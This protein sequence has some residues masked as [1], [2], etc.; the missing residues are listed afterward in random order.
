MKKAI[1]LYNEKE[2]FTKILNNDEILIQKI[3]NYD[4]FYNLKI[5]IEECKQGG[6]VIVIYNNSVK[7]NKSDLPNNIKSIINSCFNNFVIDSKIP[8][9]V[10]KQECA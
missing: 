5:S 8:D 1:Y 10:Q 7:V 2:F 9:G 6:Y 3:L 4:K